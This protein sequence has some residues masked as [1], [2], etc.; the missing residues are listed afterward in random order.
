MADDVLVMLPRHSWFTVEQAMAWR[1]SPC[2]VAA[3]GALVS[4]GAVETQRA[5]GIVADRVIYRVTDAGRRRQDARRTPSE[6]MR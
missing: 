2:T 4:A 1:P 3:L 5:E 6:G